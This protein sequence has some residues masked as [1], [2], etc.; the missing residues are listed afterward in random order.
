MTA[1]LKDQGVSLTP[2]EEVAAQMVK[3]IEKGR[4]VVYVPGK[5]R[6]IMLIIQH[7]PAVIFNKL[8]I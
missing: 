8:N 2:V 5:W 7:L 1:S 6:M 4:P 3:A